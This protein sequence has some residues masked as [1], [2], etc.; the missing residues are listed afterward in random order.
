MQQPATQKQNTTTN[1]HRK[2]QKKARRKTQQATRRRFR[3]WGRVWIQTWKDWGKL[4]M[5]KVHMNW[6]T[7]EILWLGSTCR[8]KERARIWV[9]ANVL[10]KN[11]TFFKHRH[12][13]CTLY[14]INNKLLITVL[15]RDQTGQFDRKTS[16]LVKW[17]VNPF[18]SK[19]QS[20]LVSQPTEIDTEPIEQ[21]QY[22]LNTSAK[23]PFWT[24]QFVFSSFLN[25]LFL[26][27][28]RKILLRS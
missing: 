21:V 17:P 23:K 16:E 7:H 25:F 24:G 20:E 18:N 2:V 8:I 11:I 10:A 4:F 27:Q 15:K 28:P 26:T 3:R 22:C 6:V 19:S 1:K 12:G 5:A 9:K 13:Y 14:N